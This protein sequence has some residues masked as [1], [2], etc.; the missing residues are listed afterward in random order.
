MPRRARPASRQAPKKSALSGQ[1]KLS[2][3][4]IPPKPNR[5]KF[6]APEESSSASSEDDTGAANGEGSGKSDSEESSESTGSG[7]ELVSDAGEIDEDIDLDAPRVAQWMDDEDL[8]GGR[9]VDSDESEESDDDMGPAAGPSNV[10]LKSLQDDL[11]SLPLGTLRKAQRALTSA[12]VLSDSE[13][14]GPASEDDGPPEESKGPTEKGKEKAKPEWSI[15]PRPDLAKRSNKHAPIEVTSK[16][17]VT[18]RRQ[19]VEVK[20]I[21]PRDPRFLPLAGEF[22]SQKFQNQYGFLADLHSNELKALRENLKQARKLLA[23]SP[24]DLRAERE[25]EVNRLD[26]AV[27]RAESTVNRDKREKVE[28]EAL[29]RV[30]KEEHEKRKQ[31]K[32]GWWMKDSDKKDL[33]VRAR[34]EA[35]AASGGKGAVKKAIEKKQKKIG[36]K[37]KKSRPFARGQGGGDERRAGAPGTVEGGGGRPF[38]RRKVG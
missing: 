20:N 18:R 25:N 8:D 14:D 3:A 37:E 12:K 30:E 4:R 35:L 26:M 29:S 9:S 6:E 31:G 1:Q 23:S 19:V 32:G 27:K 28:R 7:D 33:L 13:E 36:Q 21:Q 2:S 38:K 16:R 34:Y 24:R 22:S 15:K 5:V 11:S 10:Q 17:P